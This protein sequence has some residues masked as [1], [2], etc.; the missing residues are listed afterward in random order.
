ML[1]HG[2]IIINIQAVSQGHSGP[3]HGTN[4]S[5]CWTHAWAVDRIRQA[6]RHRRYAD[7]KTGPRPGHW[8]AWPPSTFREVQPEA[9]QQVLGRSRGQACNGAT[10][11]HPRQHP[12]GAQRS[13]HG[14]A[15]WQP[16]HG[17][18]ANRPELLLSLAVFLVPPLRLADPA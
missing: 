13:S 15:A 17:V 8:H 1:D 5:G 2:T 7:R 6:A 10:G 16:V 3:A 9:A 11:R 14:D 4:P 12:K 18:R